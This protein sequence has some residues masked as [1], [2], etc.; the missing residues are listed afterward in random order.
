MTVPPSEEPLLEPELVL[1][2]ELLPELLVDPDEPVP[3]DPPLDPEPLP[4]LELPLEVP[5]PLLPPDDEPPLAS[6]PVPD[7]ELA[8]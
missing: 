7:P 1:G 2:P 4:E 5:A 6:E 3:L 8:A